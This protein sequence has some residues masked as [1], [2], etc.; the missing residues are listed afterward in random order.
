MSKGAWQ[1]HDARRTV[2]SVLDLDIREL[3]RAGLIPGKTLEVTWSRG[4]SASSVAVSL[5]DFDNA[6]I[7]SRSPNGRPF[8]E[9]VALERTACNYGGARPWWLCPDCGRRCALLYL[10]GERFRCRCCGEL[11]YTTSQSS[12]WIRSTRKSIKLGRR[13]GVEAGARR[14]FKPPGMHWRTF[15]R[16]VAE[17]TAAAVTASEAMRPTLE[18]W[19]SEASATVPRSTPVSP[20]TMS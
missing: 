11:T 6:R 7:I 15:E 1:R 10:V 18:R 17:Y 14:V 9:P 8:S 2:E 19:E 12:R 5:I 20:M 3:H 4:W 13:I 16:L